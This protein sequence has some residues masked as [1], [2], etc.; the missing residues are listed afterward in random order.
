MVLLAIRVEM[1]VILK[2]SYPTFMENAENEIQTMKLVNGIITELLDPNVYYSRF[3][4]LE[5][6]K[7]ALDLK[8]KIRG[9]ANDGESKRK[10]F[11]TRSALVKNLL[12]N[13][14][15]GRVRALFCEY[16][17]PPFV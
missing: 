1:E 2:I 13:P 4:F 5:S 7:D 8:K 14:S 6:G 11:Y 12:P 9:Q 17:S 15:E 16:K 10:K 3:S